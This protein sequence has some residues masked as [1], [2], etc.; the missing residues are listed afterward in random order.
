MNLWGVGYLK[1]A[2]QSGFSKFSHI[3][4]DLPRSHD[5]IYFTRKINFLIAFKLLNK[6]VPLS[7]LAIVS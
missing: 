6:R 2:V 1:Y 7:T 4:S 5:K 3:S